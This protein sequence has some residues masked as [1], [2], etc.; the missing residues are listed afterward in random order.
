MV[1]ILKNSYC[2]ERSLFT[3]LLQVK[4]FFKKIE[5]IKQYKNSRNMVGERY[6][7]SR[8]ATTMTYRQMVA[9]SDI[10]GSVILYLHIVCRH[11]IHY[12]NI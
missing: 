9:Q 5:I 11:P 10:G 6:G 12:G 2:V 1:A 4:V 8:S 3:L 7:L